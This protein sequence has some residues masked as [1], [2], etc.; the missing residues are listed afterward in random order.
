MTSSGKQYTRYYFCNGPQLTYR[1]YE[2][3]CVLAS[4]AEY[5]LTARCWFDGV[6]TVTAV[7]SHVS[8]VWVDLDMYTQ[9]KPANPRFVREC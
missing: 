2:R 1:L 5:M 4:S 3:F 6:G 7:I 9:R 8:E